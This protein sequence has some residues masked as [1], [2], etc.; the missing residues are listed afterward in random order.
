MASKINTPWSSISDLMSA[1]MMVFLFISVS[2]AYQVSNQ[3]VELEEKADELEE[4]NDRIST[5]VGEYQDYRHLIYDDLYET[6]GDRLEEWD[7][8]IDEE[9]L[10]I[11]FR[12]PVLL[13]RAG[14]SD[15]TPEFDAILDDF[16]PEY[17]YIMVKYSSIIREVRIEGHTSSEWGTASIDDSY[18]N[19][20]TLSQARTRAA[21]RTCYLHTPEDKLEWVR[22]TVTANG[23]SFSRPI[24]VGNE[25]D[26]TRSRRVEFTVVID[27]KQKLDEILEEL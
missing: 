8:E 3:T 20:M 15:I 6:F 26:A 2:Y 4:K 19:N 1:L 18:F 27:S 11:R 17:V 22:T 24:L 16:W 10:S 14:K 23:M 12:N 25:E 13:F 5:I 9:T 7:A 21:L